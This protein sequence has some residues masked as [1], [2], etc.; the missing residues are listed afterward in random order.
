MAWTTEHPRKEG[1]YWRRDRPDAEP[2]V[3]RLYKDFTGALVVKFT[4]TDD[5]ASLDEL[6]GQWWHERLEAPP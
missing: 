2:Y 4:G 3:V 6:P 5:D 1:F